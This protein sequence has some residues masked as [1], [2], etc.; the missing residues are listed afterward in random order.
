MRIKQKQSNQ[1]ID[2][3]T[4][5]TS[6]D[7]LLKLWEP[8]TPRRLSSAPARQSLRPRSRALSP[9]AGRK[10]P[11]PPL[12]KA[13]WA[14]WPLTWITNTKLKC[15]GYEHRHCGAW[16]CGAVVFWF[17]IFREWLSSR[18]T[19]LLLLYSFVPV[20]SFYLFCGL[21]N[22][23]WSEY[24]RFWK[25]SW[26][27]LCV[28]ESHRQGGVSEGRKSYDIRYIMIRSGMLHISTQIQIL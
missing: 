25:G 7:P 19:S 26:N 14:C 12:L 15:P 10:T 20:R 6:P 18:S 27:G 9:P 8:P 22:T 3:L 1:T 21:Q 11:S 28:S 16:V 5:R 13:P 23:Y 4:R 24:F 17:G 2:Q